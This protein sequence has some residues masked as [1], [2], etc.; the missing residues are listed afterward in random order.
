MPE[1]SQPGCSVS[2]RGSGG[3]GLRTHTCRLRL[4]AFLR[5]HHSL[6]DIADRLHLARPTV[7]TRVSSIYVKLGVTGRSDAVEVIEQAGLESTEAKLTIPS[8][9]RPASRSRTA[10]G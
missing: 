7:K 4:V 9:S 10:A 2:K 8:R 5:T 6:K 3:T 1:R